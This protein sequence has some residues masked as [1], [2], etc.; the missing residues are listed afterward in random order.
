MLKRKIALN[1]YAKL[2]LG[3][4]FVSFSF[5]F[6]CSGADNTYDNPYLS[7][8]GGGGSGGGS[9]GGGSSRPAIYAT[10]KIYSVKVQGRETATTYVK[11][12]VDGTVQFTETYM[13]RFTIEK[14]EVSVLDKG[15]WSFDNN[16]LQCKP[17]EGSEFQ[18]T[19]TINGSKLELTWGDASQYTL[20]AEK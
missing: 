16:I 20:F 10:W 7:G 14:A 3:F 4:I 5:L 15:T 12:D 19:F 8:P 9:D 18:T 1:R 13:V 11:P 6:S 17:E 2:L